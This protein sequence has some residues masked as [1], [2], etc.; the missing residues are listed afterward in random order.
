MALFEYI[1]LINVSIMTNAHTFTT[2]AEFGGSSYHIY[3]EFKTWDN[4]RAICQDSG[5]D[6]VAFETE[7]EWNFVH[8]LAQTCKNL[9]NFTQLFFSILL[10]LNDIIKCLKLTKNFFRICDCSIIFAILSS[11]EC[12]W[13]LNFTPISLFLY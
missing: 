3:T 7:A 4:A 9:I 11:V 2:D 10:L 13:I 5:K 12:F 1:L 6:L 8:T